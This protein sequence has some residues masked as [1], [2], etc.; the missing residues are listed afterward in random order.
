MNSTYSD[1]VNNLA[2]V[3]EP[4][5]HV[6]ACHSSSEEMRQPFGYIL[7]QLFISCLVDCPIQQAVGL[8]ASFNI[9]IVSYHAQ[10]VRVHLR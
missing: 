3:Y 7:I 6:D 1:E 9:N 4:F 10:S 2:G 5:A 8:Q